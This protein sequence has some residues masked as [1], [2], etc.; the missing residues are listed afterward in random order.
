MSEGEPV[1]G[2]KTMSQDSKNRLVAG[3]A[4]AAVVVVVLIAAFT[5]SSEPGESDARSECESFIDSRLKAPATADYN[6]VASQDGE[7]WTVTGTVDSENGFGAKV[8]SDV[9]CELHFEGDT[10]YLDDITID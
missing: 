2:E 7:Q 1:T 4:V 3:I 9:T 6:L 10:A 8:R 5:A